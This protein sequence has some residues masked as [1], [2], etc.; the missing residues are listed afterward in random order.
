MKKESLGRVQAEKVKAFCHEKDL[1]CNGDLEWGEWYVREH[2]NYGEVDGEPAARFV[3][4]RA[5]L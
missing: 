4:E 3:V 1:V 5:G 2:L